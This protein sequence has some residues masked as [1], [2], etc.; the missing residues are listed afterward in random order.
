MAKRSLSD[1]L[2]DAVEALRAHPGAQLPQVSPRVATLVR[3]AADLRQLPR[4]DFKAR[5]KADLERRTSMM[6]TAK[7]APEPSTTKPIPEGFHTATPY[8][9]LSDAAG[10]IEFYKKAFGATEIARLLQPDGRVGHGEIRIGD[11]LVMLSD[12]FPEYGARS[13]QSLG[14][15][16]VIIHLYVEDVDGLARQA[17]AA[18]AKVLIPVKDQFYGDRSGRFVDPFGHIWIISTHKEDV[19]GEEIQKRAAAMIKQQS[20]QQREEL[21]TA[22]KPVREGFHTV[23]PYLLVQ[24]AAQLV[25]FVKQAFGATGTLRTTGA[26]GGLHAEIRIGDSMLMTGA[27]PGMPF[28]EMPTALHLYVDDAD[29]VYHKALAAGA[30][31]V[32]EPT[33]QDYGYREAGVKDSFGNH[34]YIA[35]PLGGR[36]FPEGVRTVTPYLHPRGAARLIDFLKQA[37]GAEEAARHQS[38]DGTIVH[39]K[40]RIGD[41]LIEMGEAHGPYQ[42]MPMAIYLYVSDVDALYRRALAA[43]ATSVQEPSDQPFGDRTAHVKDPF[44]NLWFIA[45]PI[46]DVPL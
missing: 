1:Q 19:S 5:L 27:F 7:P 4:Q 23:T 13:P 33:D 12:E 34:W 46:R 39:A 9:I 24:G 26:A 10:A 40:V 14:G 16:P 8:L 38:P 3:V 35:T 6:S 28:G 21:Q 17:V 15:S 36:P 29:A 31:A 2:D 20:A 30:T 43:G 25:E 18:G 11:S 44:D 32:Q 22:A 45:T 41:S 37:F 42:P